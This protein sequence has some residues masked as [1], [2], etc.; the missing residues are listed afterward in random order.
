M[1]RKQKYLGD[2]K[3][4]EQWNCIFKGVICS[5]FLLVIIFCSG[6]QR[7]CFWHLIS[8]TAASNWIRIVAE[9]Q[10]KSVIEVMLTDNFVLFSLLFSLYCIYI[11]K[12]TPTS[13]QKQTQMIFVWPLPP[14]SCF[15]LYQSLHS[16]AA[17]GGDNQA[18]FT[19]HGAWQHSKSYLFSCTLVEVP[20]SHYHPESLTGVRGNQILPL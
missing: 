5:T 18:I 16:A 12:S 19:T 1:I 6:L 3:L 7:F 9:Q 2:R 8:F 15:C 4:E 14:L 11:W 13:E 17:S 10:E 20:V